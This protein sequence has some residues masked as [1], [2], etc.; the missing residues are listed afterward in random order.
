MSSGESGARRDLITEFSYNYCIYS[1]LP[2]VAGVS[3]V[4]SGIR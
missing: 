2:K 3:S 4:E 1:R